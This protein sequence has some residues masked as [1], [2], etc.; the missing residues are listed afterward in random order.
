MIKT[1]EIVN[2]CDEV[3]R[4]NTISDFS[5][6]FNGLQVDNSGLVSKIG[7]CSRCWVCSFSKS[8]GEKY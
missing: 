2:F 8:G 3:T 7:A 5:G 6:S 1:L 4:K